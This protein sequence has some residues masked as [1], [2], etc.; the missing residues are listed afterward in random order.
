MS[1][2]QENEYFAL[3]GLG[4]FGILALLAK[5]RFAFL[6]AVDQRGLA[7]V[8]AH[9]ARGGIRWFHAMTLIG[10]PVV[11]GGLILLMAAGYWW[12]G[13]REWAAFL[14]TLLISGDAIAWCFK[15]LVA[16]S[17]PVLPVIAD[18]GY[19]FPSGHVFSATLLALALG[20]LIAQWLP[21][22]R[23][24]FSL[25]GLVGLGVLLILISRLVL[26]AHYP[27]DTLASLLL[28][29]G[30]W[31]QWRVWW[32]VL[33]KRLPQRPQAKHGQRSKQREKINW[34]H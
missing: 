19:S 11:T 29:T 17:R 7:I 25:Q 4:L 32:P 10:S 3:S 26:R 22:G 31:Y 8:S 28:A 24:R 27:S 5:F 13:H 12:R 30:W 21:A 6:T 9:L 16:R 1:R 23:L 34:G 15:Q 33:V 20:V 18:S 2:R 14:G